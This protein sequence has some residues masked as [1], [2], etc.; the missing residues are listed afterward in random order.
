MS[1][2]L[3]MQAKLDGKAAETPAP[4]ST[5]PLESRQQPR[6]LAARDA[7]RDQRPVAALGALLTGHRSDSVVVSEVKIFGTRGNACYIG[8]KHVF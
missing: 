7:R 8:R 3:T 5:E 1:L 4:V 2:F 6:H